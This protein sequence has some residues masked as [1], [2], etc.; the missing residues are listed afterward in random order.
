MEDVVINKEAKKKNFFVLRLKRRLLSRHIYIL[1]LGFLGLIL[2]GLFL[3]YL[4]FKLIFSWTGVDRYVNLARVFTFTPSGAVKQIDNR[5]NILLLG[6]AGEGHIAP[7]LTDTMILMSVNHDQHKIIL[8]SLPRDLWISSLRTKLNSVY[9]YGNKKQEKGGMILAKATVEEI[10]GVPVQY[11]AVI[12]FSGFQAFIDEMGGIEVQVERGFRDERY[13]IAGRENDECGGD[14]EYLCRYETIEFKQGITQMNGEMA[15]KYVR[16]RQS[17]DEIEG[18]DFGRAA[19]QRKVIDAVLQK[20]QDRKVMFS[21][22]KLKKLYELGV[23]MV[24]T[25]ME[26]DALA[27]LAR[28]AYE[29]RDNIESVAFN[30]E[31]LINPTLSLKYDNLYVFVPK[32]EID[33]V[34]SYNK[35]QEWFKE[36]LD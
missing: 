24:E 3:I 26:E 8:I 15:L 19:R 27:V 22:G 16:S 4:L 11:A 35:I 18:T 36:Q 21:Y 17:K 32:Y 25:D 9:Y 20:V 2:V 31:L 33:E 14:P 23:K 30:E 10:T 29:S 5:T 6:K 12:D 13:P 34:P 28:I 1:R 7:D